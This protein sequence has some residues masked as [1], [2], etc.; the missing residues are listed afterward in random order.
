[1]LVRA[2]RD[3]GTTYSQKS[4]GVAVHL[5]EM[6]ASGPKADWQLLTS[7]LGERT[8]PSDKVAGV[9]FRIEEDVNGRLPFLSVNS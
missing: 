8:F 4:I 2:N 7:N 5:E 3:R 9:N 1:M 6:S